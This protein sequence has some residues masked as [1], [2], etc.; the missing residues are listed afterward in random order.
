GCGYYHQIDCRKGILRSSFNLLLTEGIIYLIN[1][2]L[3]AV[4][5]SKHRQRG[6]IFYTSTTLSGT[7][8]LKTFA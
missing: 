4:F 6:F 1:V 8:T 3:L 7:V 5:F 2:S